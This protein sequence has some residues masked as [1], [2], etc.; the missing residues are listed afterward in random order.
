MAPR[1]TDAPTPRA[2]ES[3]STEAPS[4]ASVVKVLLT[5]VEGA[6]LAAALAAVGRQV[7]DPTPDVVV[8]G[9]V[10]EE[11]PEGVGR[12]ESHEEAIAV[13]E[14]D[15]DYVWI[16]HSDARPRPDALGALV[17]EVEHAGA[18]LGGSKLL[19]AGTG[20]ELESVG[21]STDVFGEPHSGL[22]EGEI[23]LQQYDVVREVAF[24]RSA[25][26]LVRRDL[27]QGLKGLDELLPPI[28]AG[29]DFSQR[30]RLAGG[31]VISVPSSEVYHQGRCNEGGRGW[32][33][34]AGRLRAMVTA[35]SLLTLLWLIPYDFIVSVVDSLLSLVLLRWRPAVHYVFSWGWNTYHLPSTITLRRRFK[36]VRVLGDEELFRFQAR[37]SVRLREVGSEMSGRTLSMF[38]E[39]QAIARGT[40][41]V[42]GSSGIWGAALAVMVL[43]FAMRSFVFIGVPDVGAS[44]P[45]EAATTSLERW[46][47]GWNDS[48]L[49]SPSPVHP[50]IALTGLWSVLWFG[51]EGAARTL[52]SVAVGLLALVGMGRL[53]GRLGFRGPGRY[54]SGLVLLAG[55]GTAILAGSGSWLALAA[56]ASLPW[57]VRAVFIHPREVGVRR[58]SHLG[59]AILLG[60]PL[61]AFSPLLAVIPLFSV[62]VWKVSGGKNSSFG[63][64]LAALLGAVIA[65][66]FLLGD[67]GW[68]LDSGRRLGLSVAELWPVLLAIAFVPIVFIDSAS[69]RLGSLGAFLGLVGLLA[70][71]Q[72]YGGP[73][74][75]E[76]TLVLASFGTALIVAAGLDVVSSDLRRLMGV[77]VSA[78]IL[79]LSI[80]VLGNGRL[81][82]PEGDLNERLGFASILVGDAG[83][84]RVLI[85]STQRGDIPGEARAGPGFWY[86]LVDGQGMT[87]D[88]VWLPVSL[89]GDDSLDQALERISGGGE[90]RP[91]RLLGPYSVDWLVLLGPTFRLDEVLIAQLDLVPTP[92]DPDSRVFANPVSAPLA[93]SGTESIWVRSGTGFAGEAGSGRISLAVNHDDGWSPEP[94]PHDWRATVGAVDGTASFRGAT[95]NIALAGST[96]VLLLSSLG[97]ILIGRRRR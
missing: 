25:S 96:V 35:Y 13:T 45:F 18:A 15:T 61:A 93:D 2:A 9:P 21:G 88:E 7:Y 60:I 33:E 70:A 65:V 58:L 36:P 34:Q 31:R 37:G 91:G 28:A 74:V 42:L 19:V 80:G 16:L 90:L 23:D 8:V 62:I 54:L 81:G 50:S 57:A 72:P 3:P 17:S 87:N 32:R 14:A 76:A 86:R 71:G 12:A 43:A 52:L 77:V 41:R 95:H 69:R 79:F 84:G 30:A 49:G 73:G 6:D 46:F 66:P 94:G 1:M 59:W 83:P 53:V 10:S 68:I 82:L 51:A 85:A 27:A 48:G 22:D 39:D 20:G 11:P 29:L 92:L 97:L 78:T 67:P 5:T 26:M 40:K 47:A 56:A 63:L 89:P 38:D 55:P 44:F 64:G 75:E 24:V 4:A